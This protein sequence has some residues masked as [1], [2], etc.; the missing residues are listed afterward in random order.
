MKLQPCFGG[1]TIL[2]CVII[3]ACVLFSS[4]QPY[5][6]FYRILLSVLYNKNGRK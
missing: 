2:T 1:M 6:L 5:F 4:K 3:A